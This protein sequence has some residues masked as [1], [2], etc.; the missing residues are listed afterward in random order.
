M[1]VWVLSYDEIVLLRD[2][3]LRMLRSGKRSVHEGDYDIAVFMAEQAVQLY[4]KSLVLE[5]TG[6]IPRVHSVR[7]LMFILKDL[8][9]KP[10][11]F[12]NFVREN[13]SLFI[14][15]EEAY[16]SSCYTPRRYNGGE[17]NR[18]MGFAEKVIKLLSL[19]RA[20]AEMARLV[21][22]WRFWVEG[23]ARA[24]NNVLGPC[25]VYVFGSVAEGRATGGSDVDVL[26]VAES[27]PGD[28]RVRA[29]TIARIEEVAGL[30]LYHPFQIHLAT[31]GEAEANPIYRKAVKSGIPILIKEQCSRG[32]S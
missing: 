28:F 17:A 9:G 8:M 5:L 25:V 29:E 6:E 30:P 21:R 16:I 10:G 14:R 20:K 23:I 4:L 31:R 26:I 2:R 27:L 18:L 13:R 19:L 15:L 11:V 1:E 3:A 22:E 7:Q 12:D 32:E 24:A